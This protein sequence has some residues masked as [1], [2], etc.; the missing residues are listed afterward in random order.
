VAEGFGKITHR[1]PMLSLDNAFS[2]DDVRD[3]VNRSPVPE[4]AR[5]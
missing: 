1:V 4:V 2:D 5:G 3:F